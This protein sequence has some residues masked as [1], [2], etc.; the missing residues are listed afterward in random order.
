MKKIL[1]VLSI[2]LPALLFCDA[3]P[4]PWVVYYGNKAAPEVFSS[5]NPIIFDN[6]SHPS[7]TPLLQEKKT[8]LG[9]LNMTEAEDRLPWFPDIKAQGILIRENTDWKGSWVVDIRNPFWSE[10]LLNKI[11]PNIL[12]QGFS[13]LF[14][15]QLDLVLDLEKKDPK[16][17]QGMEEAAVALVKAIHEKYPKIDLMMNRAYEIL[18]H[19]GRAINFELA[20]TL[21]TSYNFATKQYYVR[22]KH[23]FEWQLAQL[24]K[25]RLLFPKL[26]I[27]SLDYWD[28]K[29]QEMYRKI[30]SIERENHIRPYVTTPSLDEVYPEPKS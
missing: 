4:P 25:A 21:Y 30:Y 11:I 27:F 22:P 20:E 9:Y 2:Y 10:L 24:N 23:E 17:Y 8:L 7:L 14:L 26:I 15:D 18:P 3:S 19:V 28:P 12:T 16:H 29:D 13:G 5:Y 1:L 6:M